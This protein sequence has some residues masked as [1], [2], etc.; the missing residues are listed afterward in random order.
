MSAVQPSNATGAHT[1][2]VGR[3]AE[4]AE[5][6]RLLADPGI[7]L[8]TIWGPGGIGKTRLALEAAAANAAHFA[9]GAVFVPLQAVHSGAGVTAA[10]AD[11]LAIPLITAGDPHTQLLAVLRDKH[12]LVV[13]DNTE[14]LGDAVGLFGRMLDAAP[15]I[16]L[17]VTSREVLQLREEW[18]FPLGGLLLP[19][20]TAAGGDALRLFVERARQVGYDVPPESERAAAVRICRLVDGMPLAIELA[21]AW[22]RTLSCATIADEVERSLDVLAAR[23]RN[24]PER[25]ASVRAVCDQ[26][27][28]RLSAEERRVFTR[29]SP[30]HTSFSAAAAA[31]VADASLTMLDGLAGKSLLRRAPDNRYQIHD[32]LRHYGLERLSEDSAAATATAAA[33][34]EFYAR[35]LNHWY[36]ECA[37]SGVTIAALAAIVPELDTIRAAWSDILAQCDG[38]ELRRV[39]HIVQYVYFVRGPYGEGSALT[40][41]A[42]ARLQ[43]VPPTIERQIAVA[44]C[45]N[46][47]AWFRVREGRISEA[48]QLF[49]ASSASTDALA[50]PRPAGDATEPLAGLGVVALVDGDYGE[51]VRLGMAA[52]G[53]AETEGHRGNQGLGLYV[54]VGAALAQGQTRVALRYAR[55]MHALA[56]ALGN[57]WFLAYC[58]LEL[59]NIAAHAR[60]AR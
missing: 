3:A 1:S 31:A 25:H 51:A 19:N 50:L 45:V 52:L 27:W 46:S 17:L 47:I 37:S 9:A 34:G 35:L 32:L 13:L 7:R 12:V 58:R 24:V 55:R 22:T 14:Q 11:A 10:I 36:T 30:F 18:L 23:L 38:E 43:A 44:D 40:E 49:T 33:L 29:L 16:K 4:L 48:R 6:A 59:G 2:F 56:E 42:L 39:A 54:L 28:G 21:A 53:R 20:D 60:R 41:Q 5:V 57:R 15:R 8:L 26:T